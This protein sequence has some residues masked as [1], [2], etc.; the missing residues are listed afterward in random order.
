MNDNSRTEVRTRQ[1]CWIVLP[2][3]N[4]EL[5]LP[6]LLDRI[7]VAMEEAG[8]PYRVVVVDDGSGDS[9]A[10]IAEKYA[11]RIPLLL[12]RHPANM[13]LGATIRDGMLRAITDSN[14]SDIIITMDAD[15]SHN[16]ELIPRMGRLIREGNDVVIASRYQHGST[17]R[18]VSL[19]RRVLSYGAGMLF[20]MV[21]PI[22]GV[23]DYTCGYRAYRASALKQA[24]RHYKQ[25]MF[26]QAGFQCMVDI[27]LKMR[28]LDFI[29]TEVPMILRYDMKEG[30]SKMKVARTIKNTLFL[31]VRRRIGA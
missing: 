26:N 27:L 4:E 7:A 3:Y 11:Q 2:A 17:I 30:A 20:R 19:L 31:M 18:G 25:E 5:S 28:L 14:P 8:Y 15:N 10:S 24:V 9:T 16:P 13:G 12:E 6:S 22:P 29:F 21:F 23:R 1:F